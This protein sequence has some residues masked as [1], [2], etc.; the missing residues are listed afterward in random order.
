MSDR[1]RELLVKA[2]Q[3]LPPEEQVE[4][5]GELLVGATGQATQGLSPQLVTAVGRLGPR[6][7]G[8]PTGWSNTLAVVSGDMRLMPVRLPAESYERLQAWSR[9]HGFSTSVIIRTLVERFLD[10]RDQGSAEAS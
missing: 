2:V 4:V 1:L 7:V 6:D 5:L 8:D 3:G 9:E 10:E